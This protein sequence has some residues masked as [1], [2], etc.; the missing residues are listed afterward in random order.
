[1]ENEKM[2][3]RKL[4]KAIYI[5]TLLTNFGLSSY[6]LKSVNDIKKNKK[7]KYL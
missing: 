5:A 7:W 1:M 4:K 2:E 6:A 3:L